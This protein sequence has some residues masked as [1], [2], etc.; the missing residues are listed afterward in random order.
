MEIAPKLLDFIPTRSSQWNR[1][2]N[3]M[4]PWKISEITVLEMF[5]VSTRNM[6]QVSSQEKFER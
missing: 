3:A 5:K 6:F 2:H 4:L 1:A